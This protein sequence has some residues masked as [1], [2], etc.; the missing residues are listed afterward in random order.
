M[1]R[2]H[3]YGFDAIES[4]SAYQSL[5]LLPLYTIFVTTCRGPGFGIGES[6]MVTFGPLLMMASFILYVFCDL[7][8]MID[9]DECKKGDK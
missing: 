3:S 4:Y 6:W 8:Y 1:V 9:V 5:G 7:L 2:P